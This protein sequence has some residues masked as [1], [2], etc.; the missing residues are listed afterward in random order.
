M[1]ALSLIAASLVVVAAGVYFRP[2]SNPGNGGPVIYR[3]Q[4]FSVVAPSGDVDRLPA[5][6]E[7]QVVPGAA[8]YQL[9][10]LE[11]DRSEVWSAES[12]GWRVPIPPAVR[13]LM[14]PG[15]TFR[16]Q[17]VARNAAGEKI[18]STNLQNFHI[19]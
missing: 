6:F 2:D 11:V 12:T 18:A 8:K 9:R 14:R 15:R 10:L 5:D 13:L 1:R 3:S 4:R 19:Q 7:W 17:V 16:W